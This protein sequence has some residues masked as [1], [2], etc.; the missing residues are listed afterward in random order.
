MCWRRHVAACDVVPLLQ[1][2]YNSINRY[3]SLLS[4]CTSDFKSSKR[5]QELFITLTKCS[6]WCARGGAVG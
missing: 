6:T 2:V 3:I 1:S 5:Y 4:V